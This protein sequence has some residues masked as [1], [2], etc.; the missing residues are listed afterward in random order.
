MKTTWPFPLLTAPLAVLLLSL[1]TGCEHVRGGHRISD[2]ATGFIVRGSTSRAELASNFG[3][4]SLEFKERRVVAYTWQTERGATAFNPGFPWYGWNREPDWEILG[5]AD[6]AFC[7]QFD[8]Q[9]RVLKVQTLHVTGTNSL[10][11]AVLTWA[12]FY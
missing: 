6:W 5:L 12:E 11:N 8:Q 9:D 2:E 10:S 3:L 4:P 7:V 1:L